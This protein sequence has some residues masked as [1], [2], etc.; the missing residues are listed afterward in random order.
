MRA[1]K[2]PIVDP[3]SDLIGTDHFD[4]RIAYRTILEKEI[5][6]IPLSAIVGPEFVIKNLASQMSKEELENLGISERADDTI[7]VVRPESEWVKH[8]VVT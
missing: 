7:M 1:A 3:Q 2:F 5:R 8:F 4:S 6:I